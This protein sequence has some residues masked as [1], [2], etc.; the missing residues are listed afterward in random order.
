MTKVVLTNLSLLLKI[1]LQKSTNITTIYNKYKTEIIYERY[2]KCQAVF[3]ATAFSIT[4]LSIID[5]IVTLSI[6]ILGIGIDVIMLNV[7]ML[8]VVA[9]KNQVSYWKF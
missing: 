2:Q 3:G 1:I 5:T 9:P 7:V 8:S 4:T 6:T